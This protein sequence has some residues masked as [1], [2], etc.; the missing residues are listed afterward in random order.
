MKR[1]H[2]KNIENLE[3]VMEQKKKIPKE[4]KDKINAK[5]FENVIAAVIVLIY[6]AG[7]SMGMANIPTDTYITDLKV[8]TVMLLVVTIITFEYGYKKDNGY[9]W[10]HGIEVMIMAIFTLYLIYLYSIYYSTYNT[11]L[12]SV[13]V[14]YLM[15]YV[16]KIIITNRRMRK[17]YSKSLTDIGE[18]VKK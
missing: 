13:G 10:L 8:F 1:E 11:L 4:V 3:K 15:Y 6:L 14:A 5:R 16:V 7:L 18:I 9:I 2:K 12:M 17:N